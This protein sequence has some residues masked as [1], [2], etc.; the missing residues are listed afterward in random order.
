MAQK[1]RRSVLLTSARR[2]CCLVGAVALA[3]PVLP[4]AAGAQ[5]PAASNRVTVSIPE[6]P[7]ADALADFAKQAGRQ[8]VF[9]FNDAAGLRAGPVHGTYSEH[10]ALQHLLGASGLEYIYINQRMIGI[11]RRDARGRF[12]FAQRRPNAGEASIAHIVPTEPIVVTGSRMVR[13]DFQ[14]SSPIV[15]VETESFDTVGSIAAETS[16]NQLPQFVPALSQFDTMDVQSSATS[17]PGGATLNLR[18]LG[19]NRNLVLI[20]G[21]R[22]Q[23]VNGALLVD[24]NSIPTAAINRVEIITGGASAV[25]GADAVSGVVNF[26]LKKNFDGIELSGQYGLTQRGDGDE[27]RVS[28]LMGANL[29]SGRGNVMFGAEHASREPIYTSDRK[30]FRDGW[31]DPASTFGRATRLS[32]VYWTP[33]PNSAWDDNRPSPDALIALF[34]AAGANRSGPF[35]FNADNTIYQDRGPGLGRYSGPMMVDQTCAEGLGVRYVV[36]ECALGEIAYRKLDNSTDPFLR[37]NQLG[38]MISTPLERYSGFGRFHFDLS[39]SLSY[40]VQANFVDTQSRTRRVWSPAAG[41]WAV[42][43]PHGDEIYA[44]SLNSDGTTSRDYQAGGTYGLN[45]PATGGCTNSQTWPVPPELAALLA[46]R[47]QPNEPFVLESPALRQIGDRGIDN[48]TTTYQILTGLSG[49]LPVRDWTWD[50]HGSHGRTRVVSSMIGGVSVSNLRALATAPNYGRNA[51]IIGNTLIDPAGFGGKVIGCTSG[52]HYFDVAKELSQDCISAVQARM[53]HLTTLLQN[54]VEANAQGGLLQLPGGEARASLGVSYR[55]NDF[56]YHVDKLE[57]A[58]NVADFP[59]GLFGSGSTR[60]KVKAREIYGELLLPVLSRLPLI[61]SFSFDLGYRYSHYNLVGGLSTYKI[62]ADWT[63]SDSLRFRG[64]YNLATRAPNVGELFQSGTTT[65]VASSLGDPCLANTGAP[66]G[67]NPDNPDRQRVIDLCSALINDPFSEYS[68]DPLNY[69]VSDA[70]DGVG[71]GDI[72]GNPNLDAERAG[73]WT[74]GAVIRSM[75]THP[76]LSN[77]SAAIDYY[78]IHLKGTIGTLSYDDTYRRCF[79]PELN[80]DYDAQN[81]FC[82]RIRR[83]PGTG[84]AASI[85]LVNVNRGTLQTAGA[86]F[87]LNWSADVANLGLKHVP[88]RLTLTVLANYVAYYRVQAGEGGPVDDVTGTGTS[89]RYR[90]NSTLAYRDNTYDIILRHRFLPGQ[91]HP[92]S[93]VDAGTTSRGPGAYHVF[94]LAGRLSIN[95]NVDFRVGIDNFFDRSPMLTSRSPANSGLGITNAGYYDVLGRRFY[96]SATARF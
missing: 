94:D 92:A 46:S 23:P 89:F 52:L 58:Q 51:R 27:F 80:P 55:V 77:V 12:I 65:V 56:D 54:I 70:P 26:I 17:T 9:Y 47:Q 14:A 44:P 95:E 79:D 45:C 29:A 69:R 2:I 6:Q 66:Y 22:A 10:E 86:D 88:G 30:F 18:G 42:V 71:L 20:D 32:D 36:P 50:V 62:L 1:P 61:S 25:Y 72:T 85:D 43:I 38:T 59:A 81:E 63:V 7:M 90:I 75:F 84:D 68:R 21:R 82:R 4:G 76:L 53:T 15:T 93:I 83:N 19:S 87:Q 34:G 33:N 60:G 28:A 41:G 91:P 48:N 49:R 37:E 39:E 11:G 78:R 24:I 8:I 74:A 3:V 67:N 73:T 16:L 96:A 40:F 5:N 35:F 31:A 57:N 13:R 64:G